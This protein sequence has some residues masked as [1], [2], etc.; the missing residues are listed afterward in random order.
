MNYKVV[1]K[2]KLK[3]IECDFSE[4][5]LKSEKDALD[6]IATCMENNANMA[7]VKEKAFSKDF[8]NLR[9]GLAG[10]IL[11]KFINYQIKV[12]SIIEN[13]DKFND[14]FKEMV[15]EANK[16]NDFRVFKTITEA[17]NWLVS[18]K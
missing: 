11:Q 2:D 10:M 14:R 7:I 9:T 1:E 16:G 18:L 4:T 6:I 8:F 13:E 17:E 12:A 5:P 3:Y 15:L